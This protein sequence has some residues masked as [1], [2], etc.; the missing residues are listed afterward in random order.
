LLNLAFQ[1][2]NAHSESPITVD[3][4]CDMGEG[5]PADPDLFPLVT[6]ANI[7]CG[8]H[9]GD[10]GIM[11]R[12]VELALRHRVAIGAHPSYPDREDFGRTDIL[13]SEPGKGDR[14]FPFSALAGTI[15]AQ[16]TTLQSICTEFGVRLHHVKPH[17]A[18]YN[19][20]ARDQEVSGI[21]VQ[22]VKAIDPD[23]I[24][25]GLSGS[26]TP[27][28]VRQ[29]GIRFISEVFADRTYQ[30]DGSLT[31]RTQPNALLSD[32]SV[33][34]SQA[35]D[36]IRKRQVRTVGGAL[37]PITADSIC[38]HGDGEHAVS[39]ASILRDALV[40]HGIVIAAP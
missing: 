34:V 19:R 26:R 9:A 37:I 38:L 3:L 23:I 35:L 31:P 16:I 15:T 8:A 2:P 1:S 36:M 33:M 30:P 5:M 25:Y 22:T 29:A 14:P 6:S 18:L 20:A 7:A 39:F 13:E 24:I 17:G 12:S 4:N 28:A 40:Q 10:L 21:I 11:R 27:L 32:A